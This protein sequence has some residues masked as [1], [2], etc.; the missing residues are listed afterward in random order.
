MNSHNKADRE[1]EIFQQA[2]ES[3]TPEE[4]DRSVEAACGG[5]ADL[6]ARVQTL[7]RA[8]DQSGGFLSDADPTSRIAMPEAVEQAGTMIGRYKLL[9][10]IGEG[11]CGTVY[12]AEQ[13]VPVRRR[14]ALKVIKLGMDT[15]EVIARFEAERQ[16]LAMMDHPNIAKVLDAGAT[17]SGRPYFVMELVRG[18]RIT[19]YCDQ[20]S[21]PTEDRLA[22]FTLV[23]NAV[24][25]AHQKGIIHRDI[26]PSN[27]LVTVND[28]AAVPKVIDFGIAKA[29]Q[30]RLTDQTLFTA[31]EQFI[32][33]PAYMSPEQ[34]EM[35]SL[36]IDTRSDIYSL[37]VL[38]YELLTGRT[39]FEGSELLQAGLDEMRR[40]IR[41]VEPER[42][43]ARLRTMASNT[44]TSTA[45]RR[46]TDAPRLISLVHGDLDWIVMR[47]LE[48]DR[49]RRYETATSLA[50][51]LRRHL[52]SEPVSARS[53]S[54]LY[55]LQKLVRRHQVFFAAAAVITV[56]LV[57]GIVVSVLAYLNE[58]A[59][60]QYAVEA[61]LQQ[62]RANDSRIATATN[63]G[64]VRKKVQEDEDRAATEAARSSYA[65]LIMN[66]LIQAGLPGAGGAGDKAVLAHRLGTTADRL[67]KDG[68]VA[69]EA[70]GELCSALGDAFMGLGDFPQAERMYRENL[71]VSRAARG[72]ASPA[73]SAALEKLIEALRR[74]GRGAEA[75]G[76]RYE[77]ESARDA[78]FKSKDWSNELRAEAAKSAT[79]GEY[80]EAE[81]DI[82]SAMANER[83][84]LGGDYDPS[85][86]IGLL[87]GD[88]FKA[89][90]LAGTK[91]L[92]GEWLGSERASRS[93]SEAGTFGF[94]M[95]L[96]GSYLVPMNAHM[97]LGLVAL[98]E[99]DKAEAGRQ[100]LE[101]TKGMNRYTKF[102]ADEVE[103][104]AALVQAGDKIPVV[105]FL[106]RVQ[107]H[108][109]GDWESRA[110][111]SAGFFDLSWGDYYTHV[112][113][114]RGHELELGGWRDDVAAGKVPD[115]WR[116]LL[117]S[118]R[119]PVPAAGAALAPA[120]SLVLGTPRQPPFA[121]GPFLPCTLFALG[122]C[123]TAASGVIGT[124][125]SVLPPAS[126]KW[127]V[128]FCVA[129]TLDCLLFA[130]T[131]ASTRFFPDGLISLTV[132][133][134]SWAFLWEF[135]NT[136]LPKPV[137]RWEVLTERWV[138]VITVGS[139]FIGESA[140]YVSKDAYAMGAFFISLLLSMLVIFLLALCACVAAGL[141]LWTWSGQP[142]LGRR[143]S[144][145]LRVAVPLLALHGLG[146]LI[147][148]MVHGS[149]PALALAL[150]WANAA[151]PWLLAA[152]FL[153]P[154]NPR[155]AAFL[156]AV[157]PA[158]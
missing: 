144:L 62:Q 64:T 92:A 134:A 75:N 67:M 5:D 118:K 58:K 88:R 109:V 2:V 24:Q 81:S 99:G 158:A 133:I 143:Q 36:D 55:L 106:D 13:E 154:E 122:F 39:P 17:T 48:K 138:A 72:P 80:A 9:Q 32:G 117:D 54:A 77:A 121:A 47:C 50:Q 60:R 1:R 97:L 38:L 119:R 74:Q 139:L 41:E 153:A 4:R 44:L 33:T 21:L 14:V 65:V 83:R 23:C 79:A 20:N 59:A 98:K 89:G 114:G 156:P 66:D 149:S 53:P 71:N 130:S 152:G 57:A 120:S 22:L 35:S 49:T 16:A 141:R 31:F 147:I 69:P 131:L 10:K 34:A 142:A 129:R 91:V 127:L 3:K 18:I 136:L 68:N 126:V 148:P 56:S 140:A 29:T 87:A 105:E 104:P 95:H 78:Y 124:R 12:M 146:F 28:G 37:G 85:G 150:L 70:K 100:L 107:P 96:A 15:K 86:D 155:S 110:V 73:A 19:D 123:A 30:G 101:S 115:P 108:Y 27:I 157:G 42:P 40:Q 128:A 112:G 137:P 43:S 102:G 113:T 116:A 82:L 51:D 103:L 8:H 6:L 26:K 45:E 94:M 11:G 132:S 111:E 46:R 90:D 93:W 151:L 135:A 61:A 125:R 25:H 63:Y 7:L 76:L 84:R 52:D 145:C